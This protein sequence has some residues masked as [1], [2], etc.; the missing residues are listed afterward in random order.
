MASRPKSSRHMESA[1]G[2]RASRRSALTAVLASAVIVAGATAAIG[3]GSAPA[4]AAHTN[5]TGAAAT[6]GGLKVAYFDQWSIYQNA[7]YLKNVDTS[8]AADKLDYLL[9]DFENIDPTNL[10]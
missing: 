1:K 10:T 8:G 6:S 3:A 5:T 2:M 7:Y 9:Y 4:A